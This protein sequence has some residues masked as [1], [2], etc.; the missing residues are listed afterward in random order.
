M[1]NYTDVPVYYWYMTR[2]HIPEY[3]KMYF[4]KGITYV[5]FND[6]PE[7]EKIDKCRLTFVG[8]GDMTVIGGK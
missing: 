6:E 3:D 5:G 1:N 7:Y 2:E 8:I 4:Y